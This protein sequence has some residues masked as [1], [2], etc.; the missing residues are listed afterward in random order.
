ML[1][2]THSPIVLQETFSKNVLILQRYGDKMV[3]KHPRIETY[4]ESFGLINTEVF[5]L[6]TDITNYHDVIDQYVKFLRE[7]V[8]QGYFETETSNTSLADS[9]K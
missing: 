8:A 2:A 7:N 9:F 5:G 1:V 3:F 4:G 6:N